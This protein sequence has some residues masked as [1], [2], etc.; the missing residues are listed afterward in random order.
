MCTDQLSDRDYD[1]GLWVT[2]WYEVITCLR[3]E[4]DTSFTC[5]LCLVNMLLWQTFYAFS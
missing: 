5:V 3:G 2:G 4:S 1:I